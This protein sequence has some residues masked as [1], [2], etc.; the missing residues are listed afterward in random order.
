MVSERK[1]LGPVAV[2]HDY[3]TQFGGAERVAGTLARHLGGGRLI[4]SVYKSGASFPEFESIRMDVSPLNAF[5]PFR[6]NIKLAFP[7][8]AEAFRRQAPV[9]TDVLIC[10]SSGWSHHLRTSGRKVVYCHNPARWL[11]QATDY[12]AD[13]GRL[14]SIAVSPFI[15]RLRR[16]DRAAALSA[17]LYIANSRVVADRIQRAYGVQ[18]Q[19]LPPPVRTFDESGDVPC[20][21]QLPSQYALIV[22]RPRAYKNVETAIAAAAR[23]GLHTVVVGGAPAHAAQ[24]AR[25]VTF[26]PRLTDQQLS[27]VYRQASVLLAAAHEDFGLTPLEANQHGTPVVALRMGGY[28]DTVVEGVTGEFFDSLS[29]V[30]MD[31][32]ITRCLA[33]RYD[34]ATLEDHA[35]CFSEESFLNRLENLVWGP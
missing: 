25:S 16:L 30:D 17:D 31:A 7:F 11:Y 35:Q 14:G 21:L 5:K 18:A 28:L 24:R 2:A 27:R 32:A 9:E 10:S 22:S 23:V 29:A 20:N 19:V 13:A 1:T 26:L 33:S 34:S 12:A 8:L 4:T 3:V 6:T 15:P